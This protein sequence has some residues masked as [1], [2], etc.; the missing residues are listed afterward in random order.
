MY[1]FI[2]SKLGLYPPGSSRLIIHDR[3]QRKMICKVANAYGSVGMLMES[4]DHLKR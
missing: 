2:A 4:A 1:E 3:I